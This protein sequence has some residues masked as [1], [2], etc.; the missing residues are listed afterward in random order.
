MAEALYEK[1]T[2]IECRFHFPEI[3]GK[4]LRSVL[5]VSFSGAYPPGSKGNRHGEYIAIMA[6]YGLVAFQ[7]ACL[8]L[9]F[10]D[11]SYS[12]GNTLLRVFD[13][14]GERGEPPLP[15][16]AVTSEKCREAF[17]SLVTPVGASEPQW[18]YHS[19]EQ[20][21]PAAIAAAEQWLDA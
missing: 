21:V 17:L 10:S 16:L 13:E 5:I 15:V 7:P 20:A 6:M 14:V 8:V 11:L 2:E 1:P 12:W 18:H 4:I 19:L 3:H 9:D